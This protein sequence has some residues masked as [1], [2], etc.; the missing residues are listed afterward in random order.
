MTVTLVAKRV[1]KIASSMAESPPPT[2]AISLPEKKKPSQVAQEETPCPIS[3]CSCGRPSQRAEAPL[4]MI[5][6]SRMNLMH[7]DVQQKWALAQVDAGEMRHAVFGAEALRLLAHVLD[8]LRAENAFGEAGKFS[9]SVVSDSWP[10]G[11][12][13]SITNGFRLARAV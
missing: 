2:T 8:Q 6:A 10:P 12:W 9:T 13:P 11:S 4:A 5:K 1:R 3:C 7:A